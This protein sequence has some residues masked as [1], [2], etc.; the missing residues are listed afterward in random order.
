MPEVKATDEEIMLMINRS[1]NAIG[2]Q[3]RA[4]YANI[5]EEKILR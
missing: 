4:Y 2:L 1:I 3:T 5:F